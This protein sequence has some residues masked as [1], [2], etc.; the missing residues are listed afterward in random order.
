MIAEIKPNMRPRDTDEAEVA[1]A[2]W[3]A[4]TKSS[5]ERRARKGRRPAELPNAYSEPVLELVSDAGGRRQKPEPVWQ[6]GLPFWGE[7]G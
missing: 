5:S 2:G 3:R 7:S 4:P 6:S 1:G